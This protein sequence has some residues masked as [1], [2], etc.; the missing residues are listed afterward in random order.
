MHSN[1]TA[2]F[3]RNQ[4]LVNSSNSEQL[5]SYISDRIA[6][7]HEAR[8]AHL[9]TL[10]IDDLLQ[11]SGHLLRTRRCSTV[12]HI[13]NEMLQAAIDQHEERLFGELLR[14]LTN[15][16]YA[17]NEQMRSELIDPLNYPAALW[18]GA[19]EAEQGRVENKLTLEFFTRFCNP[20]GTIRWDKLV[21]ANSGNYDLNTLGLEPTS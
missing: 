4:V 10:T 2:H 14:E 12:T 17:A 6:A 7:Y 13:I 11:S 9:N 20:D 1:C 19:F 8:L 16:G 15:A 3:Y 5:R 21:E 18:S